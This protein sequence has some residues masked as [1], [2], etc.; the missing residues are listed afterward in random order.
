LTILLFLAIISLVTEK[1]KEPV[2]GPALYPA[3][4]VHEKLEQLTKDPATGLL[5]KAA[6]GLAVADRVKAAEDGHGQPALLTFDITKFKEVNDKYGH[7]SGDNLILAI[8]E[9]LRDS[10]RHKDTENADLGRVGGDEFS[11]LIDLTPREDSDLTPEQR[12]QVVMDRVDK[13]VN[14]LFDTRFPEY[15]VHGVNL[16]SGVTI[17][18]PGMSLEDFINESDSMMYQHKDRQHNDHSN[19]DQ[20]AA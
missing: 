11:A 1:N 5:N 19:S 8:S 4:Y 17:W 9:M 12:V 13:N 18:K 14:G 20:E 15:K 7:L 3:A 10:L 16:A 6:F 2:Q